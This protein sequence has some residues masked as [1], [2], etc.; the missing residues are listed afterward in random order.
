M[1]RERH[2]ILRAE[3]TPALYGITTRYVF[4]IRRFVLYLPCI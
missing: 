4:V 3:L 1:V 2:T